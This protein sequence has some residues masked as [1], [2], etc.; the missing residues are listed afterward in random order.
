MLSVELLV[1]KHTRTFSLFL[2]FFQLKLYSVARI[3][4]C[5]VR[6]YDRLQWFNQKPPNFKQMR[7][8]NTHIN[9]NSIICSSIDHMFIQCSNSVQVYWK[10]NYKY[11]HFNMNVSNIVSFGLFYSCWYYSQ[12]FGNL[13]EKISLC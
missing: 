13:V 6:G 9:R 3:V 5:S 11:L 4:F 7:K 8:K 1:N 12:M 2:S 10:S